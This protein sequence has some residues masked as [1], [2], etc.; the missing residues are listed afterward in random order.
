MGGAPVGGDPT[1][2][3]GCATTLSTAASAA[4]TGSTSVAQTGSVDSGAPDLEAALARFVAAAGATGAAV[5]TELDAL[6][7]LAHHGA[8]DLD[9]ADGQPVSR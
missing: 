3:A 9:A 1:T 7:L 8:Q 4:D 5:A 2:I 6:G